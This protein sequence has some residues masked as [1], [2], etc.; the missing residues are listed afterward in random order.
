MLD[1]FNDLFV[2][3]SLFDIRSSKALLIYFGIYCYNICSSK[4]LTMGRFSLSLY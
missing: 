1:G 4:A 2:H 3:T